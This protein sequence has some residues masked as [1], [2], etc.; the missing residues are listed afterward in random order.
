MNK[1]SNSEA[2][3]T[4]TTS[5]ASENK[6]TVKNTG[7]VEVKAEA[8]V[9][10]KKPTTRR[11][12]STASAADK[13]TAAKKTTEVKKTRAKSSAGTAAKTAAK[14]N[15]PAKRRT[16]KDDTVTI[17]TICAKLEKKVGKKISINEKIAVDIEVWG[18]E[19]GSNRKMYI[20]INEGKITVSPHTY[21]EKSFRVSLSCANAVAF[22]DGKLTLKDLIT[23]KDFY[24]EGN[25]VAAVK[26][27]SIF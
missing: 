20:E 18:F 15:A 10:A 14:K 19:D 26:L 13:K 21:D 7:T 4:K 16:K 12:K 3:K 9:A 1:Q 5:S 24:A 22:V 17:E 8:T 6:P 11:A 25:I 2:K 27:A 23:S